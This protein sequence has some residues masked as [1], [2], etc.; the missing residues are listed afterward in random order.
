M[1]Q[2]CYSTSTIITNFVQT[3][4][5]SVGLKMSTLPTLALK[6]RNIIFIWFLVKLS[7]TRTGSFLQPVL[8][9]INFILCWAW[10]FRTM[11]SY[12]RPLS[13]MYDILSLTNST[14][15]TADVIFLCIKKP[16]PN[17]WFSFPLSIYLIFGAVFRAM[18]IFWIKYYLYRGIK[19]PDC[20]AGLSALSS[21]EV[22]NCVI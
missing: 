4:I 13:I 11:I 10:T 12:K 6:S 21:A 17:S 8:H 3:I 9:I 14:H 19:Q 2:N 1:W 18:H 15:L 5:P 7:N 16:V 20:E 22:K